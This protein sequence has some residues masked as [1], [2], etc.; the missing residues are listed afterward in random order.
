MFNP[1]TIIFG[2]PVQTYTVS[3]AIAILVSFAWMIFRMRVN[4]RKA[5]FDLCLLT[6]IGAVVI[7]RIV[8]VS[9]NW[10][11]FVDRTELIWQIQREGGLNWQ[12][13]LFAGLIVSYGMAKFR[14]IDF[15]ELL[16]HAIV[17]LP[18]LSLVSWYACATA[19]CAYGANVEH[20]TDYPGWMTWLADDIYGLTMPRFATQPIGMTVSLI[21]L[22]IAFLL[23][24]QGWLKR[25]RF[26]AM[27]IAICL[28]SIAIEFL[29][30]DYALDWWGIRSSVWLS[31]GVILAGLIM[32]GAE[33]TPPRRE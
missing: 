16:S 32:I 27:L 18:W 2:R 30:G 29:R 1:I 3:L 11:F 9:L 6:L 21:L 17:I 22:L 8:H 13:S 31:G 24:W 4:Q 12:G 19:G 14:A 20:M 23:Y 25:I 5:V 28:L 33:M 15:A 7:G 26:P 10:Q